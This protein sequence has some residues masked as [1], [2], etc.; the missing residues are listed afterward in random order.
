MKRGSG[1]MKYA[2]KASKILIDGALA[3]WF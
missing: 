2:K 1:A 3:D